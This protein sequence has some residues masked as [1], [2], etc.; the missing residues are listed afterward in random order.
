VTPLGFSDGPAHALYY[1]AS[2]GSRHTPTT[3]IGLRDRAAR[4]TVSATREAERNLHHRNFTAARV[5][6]DVVRTCQ[7]VA[8][9]RLSWAVSLAGRDVKASL[10]IA[11]R[12]IR[13]LASLPTVVRHFLGIH[14]KGQHF[15]S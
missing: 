13:R 1:L 4:A 7:T 3:V 6:V 5:K 2:E 11:D 15:S 14:L 10:R 12:R 9:G 8:F